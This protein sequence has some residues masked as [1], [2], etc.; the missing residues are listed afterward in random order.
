MGWMLARTGF[1]DIDFGK[2]YDFRVAFFVTR[3]GLLGV[4]EMYK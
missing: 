3:H 1:L 4:T 2:M